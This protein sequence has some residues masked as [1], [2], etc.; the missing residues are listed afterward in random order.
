MES[1]IEY[2]R[3]RGTITPTEAPERLWSAYQAFCTD[4][5]G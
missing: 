5:D 3:D 2:D 4:L 1:V